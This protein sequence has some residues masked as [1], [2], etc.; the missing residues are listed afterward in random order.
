MASHDA[1]FESDIVPRSL[2]AGLCVCVGGV[3][4]G[5]SA[6]EPKEV[7][8]SRIRGQNI[9]LPATRHPRTMNGVRLRSIER[10]LPSLRCSTAQT[11]K[12]VL[13]R[14]VLYNMKHRSVRE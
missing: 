12:S 14:I 11:D 8:G 5:V 4:F 10:Q 3:S 13:G 6:V 7:R 1:L 2:A 9:G